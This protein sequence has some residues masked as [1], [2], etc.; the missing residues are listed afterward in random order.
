MLFPR[1]FVM[2]IAR[3]VSRKV[4]K[5]DLNEPD[6]FKSFDELKEQLLFSDGTPEHDLTEELQE[7]EKV[8]ESVKQKAGKMPRGGRSNQ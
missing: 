8:F 4:A 5:L 3:A 7:A 1:L 6:L 2:N